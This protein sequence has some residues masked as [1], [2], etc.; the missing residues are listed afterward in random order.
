MEHLF[1]KEFPLSREQITLCS[2]LMQKDAAFVGTALEYVQVAAKSNNKAVR[3]TALSS[4][5]MLVARKSEVESAIVEVLR[6]VVGPADYQ[7]AALKLD[8]A[9]AAQGFDKLVTIMIACYLAQNPRTIEQ[10]IG[11]KLFT[12][13]VEIPELHAYLIEVAR[14]MATQPTQ[15]YCGL[16]LFKIL[17]TK[18]QGYED[19]AAVAREAVRSPNEDSQRIGH[20]L[21]QELEKSDK[22][23]STPDNAYWIALRRA[24]IDD[25]ERRIAARPQALQQ[26]PI[27]EAEQAAAPAE[28]PR[29]RTGLV[30]R[31]RTWLGL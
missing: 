28:E 2:E 26:R 11:L 5:G 30:A 29:R 27:V 6:M 19:A 18:E 16:K 13:L 9:L 25:L 21:F 20:E 10:S 12:L 4:F 15:Q 23:D 8:E 3:T 24:R 7:V 1:T 31:I 17:F 22:Y 14:Y